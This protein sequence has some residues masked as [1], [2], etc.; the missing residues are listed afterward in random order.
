MSW[1]VAVNRVQTV[2]VLEFF[3]RTYGVYDGIA[4][5]FKCIEFLDAHKAGDGVVLIVVI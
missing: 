1:I 5:N 3:H 4:I 2:F